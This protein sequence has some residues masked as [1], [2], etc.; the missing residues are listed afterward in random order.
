MRLPDRVA[1]T[2]L[3]WRARVPRLALI[4]TAATLS[5]VGLRQ[6]VRPVPT[7]GRP[8]P[9][10]RPSEAVAADGIAELFAR[11]F[12]T[13]GADVDER[14]RR[15]ADLGLPQD[16]LADERAGRTVTRVDWTTVVESH[17]A[18]QQRL[19]TIA[20]GSSSEVSYL[21]VRVARDRGGWHVVAAPAVVGG[22]SPTR[23]ATPPAEL[24]VG[25]TALK[26]TASRVVRHYLAGERD[27]LSADL[28]A[29][30]AVTPPS[31]DLRVKAVQ[32][33]TWTQQPR[34]IAVEAIIRSPSGRQL[35]LRYE[36]AVARVG[37][38]WLVAGVENSSPDP[39][40]LP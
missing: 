21:A 4:L 37:G 20:V 17:A 6:L 16:G 10:S 36:L 7:V 8:V 39:E 28:A 19:V 5:A 26:A 22:P 27:D 9:T 12:V 3:R 34:R 15:L 31:T 1:L 33:V 11:R 30:A 35:S 13:D 25:D 29:G 23:V 38:R 40:V 32:A 2:P 14:S 24:E 18:G